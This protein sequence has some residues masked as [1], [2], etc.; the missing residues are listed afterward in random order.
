MAL[1]RGNCGKM[2]RRLYAFLYILRFQYREGTPPIC[3]G[4]FPDDARTEVIVAG[5]AGGLR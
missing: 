2:P 1:E 5:G 3:L 4:K